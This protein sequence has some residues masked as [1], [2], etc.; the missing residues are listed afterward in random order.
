MHILVVVSQYLIELVEEFDLLLDR[1]HPS[2]IEFYQKEESQNTFSPNNYVLM[3]Q[4][5]GQSFQEHLL[6]EKD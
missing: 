4:K 1:G 5:F 2:K 3:L 6:L